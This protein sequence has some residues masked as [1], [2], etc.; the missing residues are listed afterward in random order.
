VIDDKRI[1]WLIE[2]ETELIFHY[3]SQSKAIELMLPSKQIQF[4]YMFK[5]NDLYERSLR[6]ISPSV[7]G[8]TEKEAQDCMVMAGSVREI[9]HDRSR[10]FCTVNDCMDNHHLGRGYMNFP[11]WWHY[12]A[13][14]K[15]VCF[16]FDKAKLQKAV[17][18]A[19]DAA[20]AQFIEPNNI[21]YD[22][23]V[24]DLFPLFNHTIPLTDDKNLLSANILEHM[25]RFEK[26]IF[27]TKDS[28][29][30]A[31]NE[32]RFAVIC[33]DDMPFHVDFS[34]SIVGVVLGYKFPDCD[35]TRDSQTLTRL[36]IKAAFIEIYNGKPEIYALKL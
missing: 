30:K 17:R 10:T 12:A 33:N 20:S 7:W 31:E 23:A 21:S 2:P 35:I 26:E 18:L 36:N 25:K 6:E 14:N 32:Y 13:E 34:D 9:L 8:G 11:L 3:T 28:T 1:K 24:C 16:V 15:G 19:A 29:W 4:G 22:L 27:F 5:S